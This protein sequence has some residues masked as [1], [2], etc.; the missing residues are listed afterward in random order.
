[1]FV[2]TLRFDSYNLD[3]AV[4]SQSLQDEIK[5]ENAVDLNRFVSVAED[6]IVKMYL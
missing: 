1:M 6:H 2:D 3:D 5:V 4:D